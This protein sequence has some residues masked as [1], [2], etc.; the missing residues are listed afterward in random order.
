MLKHWMLCLLNREDDPHLWRGGRATELA[1]ESPQIV[2][3]RAWV[4]YG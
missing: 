2:S 4:D 1:K 3:L